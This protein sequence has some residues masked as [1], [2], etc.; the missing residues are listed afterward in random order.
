MQFVQF[1]CNIQSHPAK[2]Y[3][4]FSMILHYFVKISFFSASL[5]TCSFSRT[6]VQGSNTVWS[7]FIPS[8]IISAWIFL[9][10]AF[11]YI[12][13]ALLAALI[14][15][16]IIF[17]F[18]YEIVEQLFVIKKAEF[19]TVICTI[20][21]CYKSLLN[22]ESFRGSACLCFSVFSLCQD[23]GWKLKA[24]KR[25]YYNHWIRSQSEFS[26]CRTNR[27][28]L[29]WFDPSSR[30]ESEERNLNGT[31]MLHYRIGPSLAS[32]LKCVMQFRNCEVV[33]GI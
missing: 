22:M 8:V 28:F 18:D 32:K 2:S 1:S 10:P 25:S 24:S 9:A 21:M 12:P 17:K 20:V 11:K 5:V 13:K 27:E 7:L 15:A 6:A 26:V 23:L 33:N 30:K 3:K 16:S 31:Q 4:S 29:C 14:M 19:V